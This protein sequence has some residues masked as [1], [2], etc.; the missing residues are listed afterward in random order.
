LSCEGL[1]GW[2]TLPEMFLVVKKQLKEA[3][4]KQTSL[5][6]ERQCNV[7]ERLAR[8]QVKKNNFLDGIDGSINQD[9]C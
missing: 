5:K 3:L 6:A 8:Y 1:S 4:E 9:H 2:F 7:L